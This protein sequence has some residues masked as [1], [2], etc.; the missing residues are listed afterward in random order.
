MEYLF[1]S[2]DEASQA[3]ARF[4]ADQLR[5]Q[6]ASADETAL[7]V[8]GG[9]SPVRCFD[10]LSGTALPWGRVRVLLSD[11]RWVSPD[12]ADSNERLLRE[13]LL[14]GAAGEAS[15][16]PI[17]DDGS[18]PASRCED[19]QFVFADV[20][21][22]RACALLG[23]GADGH[24]AS[25]FPDAPNLARGLDPEGRSA[26]IPVATAASPHPRI[27]MTLPALLDSK[28]VLLLMF[29]K[30]K[31]AVYEAAMAEDSTLPVA[32]LLRQSQT[33]VHVFW[34]E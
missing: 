27:S 22:P 2:R 1:A 21:R 17:F 25:L 4:I 19:L 34:A 30:E 3:A 14:V 8:S 28:A 18:D 23:M 16:L 10:A 5:E 15:L 6:L 20:P 13:H 7:V 32:H 11:E 12:S 31:R 9:S 24:F 29:G 26:F 33:P